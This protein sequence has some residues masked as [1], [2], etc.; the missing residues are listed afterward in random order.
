MANL[1]SNPIAKAQEL[2]IV[3]LV[4][5]VG[6]HLAD[7]F[8]CEKEWPLSEEDL[9]SLEAFAGVCQAHFMREHDRDVSSSW[10]TF[11]DMQ[12]GVTCKVLFCVLPSRKSP[13]WE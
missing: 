13:T 5:F 10:K 7:E 9:S 11:L 12:F 1:S 2:G 8:D 3:D 4:E 6:E